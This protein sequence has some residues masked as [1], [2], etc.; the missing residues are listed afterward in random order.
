MPDVADFVAF[1]QSLRALADIAKNL[2]DI[3]DGRLMDAKVGE[4]QAAIL[5]AQTKGLTA[6]A[7]QF[8]L[9]EQVRGLKEKMRELEAWDVEKEKYKLISPSPYRDGTFVYVAK[10]SESPEAGP[11]LCANCFE[12]RHK[13]ILQK[14]IRDPGRCE[15]LVCQHCSS[16]IYLSGNR[17]P[18]HTRSAPRR[19]R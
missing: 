12:N 9:L 15:V 5:D 19:Q 1:A 10:Q 2:L 6:N 13:A 3:R 14:E 18:E 7:G 11:Y 16:D 4:L 8:A 17:E